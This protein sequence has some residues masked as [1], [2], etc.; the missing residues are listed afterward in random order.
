M[1]LRTTIITILTV[2]SLGISNDNIAVIQSVK[3]D[4]RIYSKNKNKPPAV[5]IIGRS[6][7]ENDIIRTYG[8]GE[9]VV[10]YKD[11][12][13]YLHMG[14]KTEVQFIESLLTRTLNVNYGNV[15]FYQAD[16]PLK[17]LYVFTLA[18][19]INVPGGKIWLTSNLS[20]DDEIYDLTGTAQVYNEISA[21]GLNVSPGYVAFSTLDGFF[22]VVRADQSDLPGFVSDYLETQLQLEQFEEIS[23]ESLKKVK[24][25]DW[26]LIPRYVVDEEE[27]VEP[28]DEGFR[29]KIGVG[30]VGV[31]DEMFFKLA[32]LPY[33]HMGNLRVGM[34]LTGYV[35]AQNNI[36]LNFWGDMYDII[37]KIAYLDYFASNGKTY[38]HIGDLSSV[39]YGYGQLLRN[40][41]NSQAYPRIQRTG[42]IGHYELSENFIDFEGFIS[43]FGDFKNSGGLIGLRSTIFLSQ[44][45]PMTMGISAVADVNQYA[46]LPDDTDYWKSLSDS[47][48]SRTYYGLAMDASYELYDSYDYSIDLFTENVGIWYPEERRFDREYLDIRRDGAWGFTL[49]GIQF[50]YR[51]SF[52]ISAAFHYNSS[53]FTPNFFN[54]AYDMERARNVVFDNN[55]Q[56]EGTM[57]ED[58]TEFYNL[59]YFESVQGDTTNSLQSLIITKDINTIIDDSQ[60][61]YRTSGYSVNLRTDLSYIGGLEVYYQDL[62]EIVSED[63]ESVEEIIPKNYQTLDFRFHLNE[64]VLIGVSEASLY[65]SQYNNLGGLNFAD[66]GLNSVMGARIGFEFLKRMSIILDFKDVYY[67]TDYNGTVERMRAVNSEFLIAF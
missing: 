31:S 30:G 10:L 50:G 45:L 58:L 28:L 35:S 59:I 20:G 54:S 65:F 48:Y 15:F 22:E 39:T 60:N 27:Y 11:R 18:S 14:N 63:I 56:D 34:D 16:N 25:R 24:L 23:F 61:K 17:Q 5:A 36:S 7:L 12:Q 40:Y 46:G 66:F 44:N 43:D 64:K 33:Y 55:N 4:V 8:N 6:I 41:T 42:L 53:L 49:P 26:D 62:T 19:Q 29:Y 9:C 2:F 37:D 51:K 21:K 38:L 32:V 47:T 1:A 13:T 67:D 52:S 3:G 57:L